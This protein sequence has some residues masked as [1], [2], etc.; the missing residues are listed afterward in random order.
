MCRAGEFR[1]YCFWEPV[2]VEVG[3]GQQ[4]LVY[5][6]VERKTGDHMLA[7]YGLCR[8]VRVLRAAASCAGPALAHPQVELE[9]CSQSSLTVVPS[10]VTFSSVYLSM[11]RSMTTQ[12][13]PCRV[14]LLI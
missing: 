7:A 14:L 6:T 8:C 13:L 12:R 10:S 4:Q 2:L 9:V 1:S 5:V 11:F 3:G